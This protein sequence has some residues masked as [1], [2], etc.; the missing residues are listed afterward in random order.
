MAWPPPS[1]PLR[2]CICEKPVDCGDM[3]ERVVLV[4]WLWVEGAGVCDMPL[5]LR[6]GRSGVSILECGC[7][8][9]GGGVLVGV[10]ERGVRGRTGISSARPEARIRRQI[11]RCGGGWAT[12]PIA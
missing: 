9:K 4:V 6:D 3:D 5:Y 8:R 2:E 7:K 10:R 11:R 1:P 12:F